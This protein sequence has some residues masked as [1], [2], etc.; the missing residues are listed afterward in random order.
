MAAAHFVETTERLLQQRRA[1]GNDES[2]RDALGAIYPSLV[3][4]DFR[5]V[6]VEDSARS[7]APYALGRVLENAGRRLG[8]P[9]SSESEVEVLIR[10]LEELSSGG[11]GGVCLLTRPFQPQ[12]TQL[13]AIVDGR[14]V[15]HRG[16]VGVRDDAGVVRNAIWRHG[17]SARFG[18]AGGIVLGP[19]PHERFSIGQQVRFGGGYL[20]DADPPPVRLENQRRCTEMCSGPYVII[21]TTE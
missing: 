5:C 8:L 1:A 4:S 3:A 12:P 11:S 14:L 20:D 16:C 13:E 15:I 19:R 7:V 17:Y 9:I 2:L 10:V 18:A 6:P 21:D